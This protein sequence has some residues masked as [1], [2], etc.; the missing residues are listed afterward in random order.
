MQGEHNYQRLTNVEVDD[1]GDA[2]GSPLGFSDEH[3][4]SNLLVFKNDVEVLVQ[5]LVR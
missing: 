4:L 1:S 2:V 5:I 3:D